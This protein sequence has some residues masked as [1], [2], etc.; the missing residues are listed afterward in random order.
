MSSYSEMMKENEFDDLLKDCMEELPP[1]DIVVGVTPWKQAMNRIL[2]GLALT[3]ITF[4]F[5]C[6]DYILPAVGM[7]LM[8]LGFRAL[9]K[10]NVWFKVSWTVILVRCVYFFG[11]LILNTTI[12]RNE[13]QAFSMVQIVSVVFLSLT[14]VQIF[15][16]WMGIREVQK[17]AD[18]QP[19]AGAALGLL[20]WNG[21]ICLLA[22]VGIVDWFFFGVLL[23]AYILI[24]RSL[25]K[26]SKELNEAGYVIETSMLQLSDR[27][28]ITV[29]LIVLTIGMGSGYLFCNSYTM[30]WR[31]FEVSTDA[32]VVE[33]KAQLIELG[34][35]QE[36][37]QDVTEADVLACEGALRVVVQEHTYPVNEGR[38][39]RNE[40]AAATVFSTVYDVKELRITGIAVEL[41]DDRETWKIF[42][43]FEW[44]VN[45]GFYGT[46]SIQLWTVYDLLQEGWTSASDLSGHVLYNKGEDVYV[47]SYESISR[48]TYIS[49]NFLFGE[50]SNTELF[51]TFSLPDNGE[52]Q[53]GYLSYAVN[54]V[55]DGWLIDTWINYTHQ[56][57]GVQYPVQ[58]AKENRMSDS[59]N[60]AGTFIL[61]QDALQFNPNQEIDSH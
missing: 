12:Y 3:T 7:L 4:Q 20:I 33:I 13:I 58:T 9:R 18:L 32:K 56:Q 11:N 39:V 35:P 15:C 34:F 38:I 52:R 55:N 40:G 14:F 25:Y 43:H 10:E 29:I 44:D 28:L 41:P 22:V 30:D 6:L 17:K 24:I 16:L 49:N 47:S 23:F 54:E 46:E 27:N 1:S 8:L 48:E 45:P 31:P 19:K 60:T 59:W 21:I 5:Y 26:L 37:L 36:V 2:W 61:I 42:H 57:H 53:R 51:A 50:Q